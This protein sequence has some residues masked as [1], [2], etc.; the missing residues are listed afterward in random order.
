MKV[1]CQCGCGKEAPIY[2]GVQMRFLR[3]HAGAAVARIAL[4][5]VV[6]PVTG[7]WLWQLAKRDGY[8]IERHNGKVA[9]A[10]VVSY[11][12]RKGPIPDGMV[13]DHVVCQ[14]RACINP[15]HVE[16]VTST[17]NTQRRKL[18]KIN[19]SIARDMRNDFH[20]GRCTKSAIALERGLSLSLV[21]DVIN[22]NTWKEVA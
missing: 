11:E 17:V 14:N 19:M 10:H 13:L 20:S 12:K 7:C 6:D 4:R 1:M 5:Y 15:D 9:Q 3:G 2:R 8:G 22:N 18:S 21:C 16:P